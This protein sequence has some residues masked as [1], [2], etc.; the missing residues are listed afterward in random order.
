MFFSGFAQ[1]SLSTFKEILESLDMV[2]TELGASKISSN[3]V[4]KLKNTMSDCHAA[5]K[6]FNE[7]LY[8]YQVD[9]LSDIVDC[10]T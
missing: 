8:E 9:I 4:S 7:L 10:L 1:D 2:Q 6:L 3:I 5:E